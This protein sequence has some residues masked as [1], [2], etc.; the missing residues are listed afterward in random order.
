MKYTIITFDKIKEK[1][2]QLGLEEY[3]QRLKPYHEVEFIRLKPVNR[4]LDIRQIK[5]EESKL[6]MEKISDKKTAGRFG[7]TAN[8]NPKS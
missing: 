1:Y 7:G 2:F 8:G 3:L 5:E 6:L 4:K